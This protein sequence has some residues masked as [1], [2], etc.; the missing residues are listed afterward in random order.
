MRK[1]NLYFALFSVLLDAAMLWLAMLVA[2][3]WRT[4]T[5][6]AYLWDVQRYSL[7]AASF[8]P[9]WLILLGYQGLYQLRSPLRGWV[10]FT[11]SVTA[12][13][14]GWAIILIYLYL[15]RSPEALV[16]PRLIIAYGIGCSIVFILAGRYLLVTLKRILHR[17][18]YGL[19]RVVV[20]AK[21]E[22]DEI[23]R[24]LKEPS[25][26]R[27]IQAVLTSTSKQELE[28]A[29]AR[30]PID[31]IILARSGLTEAEVLDLLAW[32]D[33]R[34]ISFVQLS[35]PLTVRS[36]NISMEAIAG[37]PVIKYGRTRL[38]GWGRIVKR[39]FD[40]V[41]SIIL[42]VLLSPVLLLIALLITIIDR[43]KGGVLFRE[44][45]DDA[46]Y[47]RVG[48]FGQPFRYFKFRTMRPGT[49]GLRDGALAEQNVR[50]GP[51][52]KIPDDPRVTPLGK[53]LRKYSLDELPE[54]FLVLFG[55]MSLVG[56]RPHQ[57]EEVA[58]Y[59]DHQRQVLFVKPG[60]TGLAQVSGRS[61]LGFED[62]I[63][64]EMYYIENWSLWLD[65]AI[66]LR[67]PGAVFSSRNRE[68]L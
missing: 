59:A 25:G 27:S 20:L 3:H 50:S 63:R 51:L 2:Y 6:P 37:L 42:I 61:E 45:D 34:F 8:L 49:H 28:Q 23:V 17:Y 35:T 4:Y 48:Q 62:E 1:F 15:S 54:L 24:R 38:D 9:V 55:R 56:P 14:S 22:D 39:L 19:T 29:A 66:L 26:T 41:V 52:V 40:I 60:I 32:A 64:L 11:R 67:T 57:P 18:G 36:G 21:S 65:I 16:F 68:A 46:P 12:I 44:L 7:F 31:E 5:E 30:F 13:L 58:R 43:P 33:N 47:T 53:I 10:V